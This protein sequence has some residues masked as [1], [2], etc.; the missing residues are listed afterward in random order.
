MDGAME[1][2][3]RAG[4]YRSVGWDSRETP[5]GNFFIIED[6]QGQGQKVH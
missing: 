3:H 6:K 5:M 1:T 4:Q 2:N